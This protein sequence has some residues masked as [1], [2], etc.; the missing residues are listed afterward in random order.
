MRR[1]TGGHALDAA[2]AQSRAEFSMEFPE[3][4]IVLGLV[5]QHE[6][7]FVPASRKTTGTPELYGKWSCSGRRFRGNR[8]DG[9]NQIPRHA[10]KLA[11]KMEGHMQ[12]LVREQPALETVNRPEVH[13]AMTDLR[14]SFRIGK[15]ADKE[16]R[17]RGFTG[18]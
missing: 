11:E 15:K 18:G 14:R 17:R 10:V 9:F 7:V 8:P 2:G 16:I 1:Q 6:R 4:G 13:A 3:R 12:T 5:S